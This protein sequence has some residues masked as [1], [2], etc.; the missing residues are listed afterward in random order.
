MTSGFGWKRRRWARDRKDAVTVFLD[1]SARLY[2]DIVDAL[3]QLNAPPDL[4][5]AQQAYLEAWQ[6][7]LDLIVKVRDAGF[8]S[9]AQVSE[10]ARS[11]RLP[12]CGEGDEGPMRGPSGGGERERTPTRTPPA[13]VVLLD[14]GA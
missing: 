12:R 7:Q 9:S 4:A 13:A 11:T 10:G 2:Q 3:R 5:A 14:L 8:P 6:G 1:Q